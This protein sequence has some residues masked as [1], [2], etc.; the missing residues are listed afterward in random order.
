MCDRFNTALVTLLGGGSGRRGGKEIGEG[1]G[2]GADWGGGGRG[3]GGVNGLK[4]FEGVCGVTW[5]NT[6][7]GEVGRG[8][9]GWLLACLLA[10]RPSNIR[11]YLRDGS[12]H[13]ILRAAT[14]RQ[15]SQTKLSTVY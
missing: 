2:S 15:K 7:V 14:L 1:E 13:T 10:K 9:V 3:R 5:A 8:F 4:V 11:V 6:F 12:A